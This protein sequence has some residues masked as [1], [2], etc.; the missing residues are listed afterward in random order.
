MASRE[1]YAIRTQRGDDHRQ[2]LLVVGGMGHACA[3]ASGIAVASPERKVVCI[4]GDGA[5]L[6]H[7]GN[8]A[9]SADCKNLVH[10]V[11]NN[12]AH[13]SVGGQPTKGLTIDLPKLACSFGYDYY[14]RVLTTAELESKLPLLFDSNGSVF[15]EIQVMPGSRDNLGRPT[16]SPRDN[17]GD[18]MNFL[19]TNK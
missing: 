14:D 16:H 12:G 13:D 1:L 19:G 3:V 8:L 11:I 5:L 18:F 9:I 15:L 6:M 10:I 17:V 2:D 7:T 4:D